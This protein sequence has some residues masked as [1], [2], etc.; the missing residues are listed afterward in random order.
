MS[1]GDV[2]DGD[3]RMGWFFLR[4]GYDERFSIRWME[5]PA[6][7]HTSPLFPIL[8]LVCIFPEVQLGV[9]VLRKA[10]RQCICRLRKSSWA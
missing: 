9:E 5:S 6:T 7:F 4:V 1:V 10:P 3:G 8:D 2:V